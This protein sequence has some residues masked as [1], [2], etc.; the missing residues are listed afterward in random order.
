MLSLVRRHVPNATALTGVDE[1]GGEGRVYMVDDHL[2]LK[3]QRPHRPTHRNSLEKEA[4]FLRHLECDP[5]L[6]APRV[7]GYGREGSVEYMCMTRMPGVA[8]RDVT[9]E[10]P[11][12]RELLRSLGSALRRIHQ[13]PQAPLAGSGL[14]PGDN[15]PADVVTRLETWFARAVEAISRNPAAWPL[16]LPPEEAA[17]RVLGGL[18]PAEERVALHTSPSPIHVFVDPDTHRFT[19]LID[20]GDSFVSHPALDLRQWGRHKDQAALMEGYAAE[21]PVDDAFMAVW[22]TVRVLAAMMGIAVL[23]GDPQLGWQGPTLAQGQAEADEDL[24]QLL[25]DL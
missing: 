14:F 8:M 9:L 6:S 5:E 21:S 4:F 19:G 23:Q 10:G 16:E 24:R 7:L 1:T 17:R 12:R 2:A 3:V 18:P 25:S 13:V 20:F 22:H 15:S 11:A